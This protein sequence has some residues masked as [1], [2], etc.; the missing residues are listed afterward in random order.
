ME[1]IYKKIKFSMYNVL[2][3]GSKEKELLP[4]VEKFIKVRIKDM[5][6]KKLVQELT[7]YVYQLW[8]RSEKQKEDDLAYLEAVLLESKDNYEKEEK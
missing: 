2:W 6:R 7:Y 1:Y 8:N 3:M 4:K 5:D